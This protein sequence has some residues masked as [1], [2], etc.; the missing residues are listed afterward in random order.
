MKAEKCYKC[1]FRDG[2]GGD[3]LVFLAFCVAIGEFHQVVHFDFLLI[4]SWMI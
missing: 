4:F 3:I 1:R 2:L